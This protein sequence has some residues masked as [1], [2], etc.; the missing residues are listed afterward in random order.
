MGLPDRELTVAV[1]RALGDGQLVP[2]LAERES[3]WL[4]ERRVERKRA[5]E[6][7]RQCPVIAE[8]AALADSLPAE[9]GV[10]A[11]IDYAP[12]AGR[13]AGDQPPLPRGEIRRLR[14]LVGAACDSSR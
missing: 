7:C 12:N 3:L 8:C 5:A 4:S 14:M 10:W 9:Y 6:L 11:G 2:C 13:Q 1:D